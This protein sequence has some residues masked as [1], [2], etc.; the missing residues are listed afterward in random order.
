[1]VVR[2]ELLRDVGEQLL[3]VRVVHE[4]D[5]GVGEREAASDDEIGGGETE[6]RE[7]D[8]LAAPAGYEVFEDSRGAA[9]VGGSC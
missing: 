6:E 1:M 3:A 8:E 7:D 5:G 2:E 9:A 4:V